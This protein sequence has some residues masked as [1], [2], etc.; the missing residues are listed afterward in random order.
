MIHYFSACHQQRI[1]AGKPDGGKKKK[2]EDGDEE[3]VMTKE[4]LEK[5]LF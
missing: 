4:Y 3:V 2:G 5:G 1:F